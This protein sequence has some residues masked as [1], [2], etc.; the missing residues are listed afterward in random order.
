MAGPLGAAVG[1]GLGQIVKGMGDLF[2]A[3]QRAFIER[4]KAFDEVIQRAGQ[5]SGQVAQAQAQR[6][7]NAERIQQRDARVL[8]PQLAEL[9]RAKAQLD[10]VNA[11][12]TLNDNLKILGEQIKDTRK[13][14][15]AQLKALERQVEQAEKLGQQ[16][17]DAIK[18]GLK[19]A[20]EQMRQETT[21]MGA[22]EDLEAAGGRIFGGADASR[23][24]AVERQADSFLPLL[25]RYNR[26]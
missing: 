15:E 3:G 9:E 18:Q 20:R 2:T 25:D 23:E 5:Y 21:G 14:A 16:V 10:T 17:P 12:K 24:R 13:E 26:D 7:V 1:V 11:L 6:E 4:S 22:L 19:E 8:G